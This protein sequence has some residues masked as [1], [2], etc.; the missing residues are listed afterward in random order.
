[1]AQVSSS[2]SS[3]AGAADGTDG[4]RC[5]GNGSCNAGLRCN[6]SVCETAAMGTEGGACFGN[7]SC[8]LGLRCNNNACELVFS[9]GTSSSAGGG[10]SSSTSGG[11]VTGGEG[12]ACYPNSTCDLG[13]DCVNNLC[14]RPVTGNANGPC[15]GNGTC[16]SGLV[17]SNNVCL[18]PP[19]GS[20]GGACYPNLTCNMGLSC[21]GGGCVAGGGSSSSS[22]GG[23]SSSSGGPAIPAPTILG[24]TCDANVHQEACAALADG[25][26]CLGVNPD[27]SGVCLKPNCNTAAPC[28]SGN[29]CTEL[30]DPDYCAASCNGQAGSCGAGNGCVSAV[31]AISGQATNIC[32]SLTIAGCRTDLTPSGCAEGLECAAVG[33]DGFGQCQSNLFLGSPCDP[34]NQPECAAVGGGAQCVGFSGLSEDQGWCV[35]TPCTAGM[36]C[37]AAGTMCVAAGANNFCSSS[38][39]FVEGECGPGDAC[40]G[41]VEGPVCLPLFFASCRVDQVPSGCPATEGCAATGTDGYGNCFPGCDVFAPTCAGADRCFAL[42]STGGICL[43]PTDN[44]A[45]GQ[46]CDGAE[47]C[48]TGLVCASTTGAFTCTTVCDETHPCDQGTCRFQLTSPA[49]GF[50]E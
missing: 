19:Q 14:N 36:A 46:A 35:V 23:G 34:T 33:T 5:Y 31:D 20:L 2:S 27:G 48:G 25:A 17:C 44:R 39:N 16:N 47:Q 38:C 18:P 15:F 42:S 10:A 30:G 8:N 43:P 12:G 4:G 28:A 40:V 1:V 13:L 24:D 7:G 50:C 45:R 22:G 37:G 32:L 41:F 11:A 9:G 3:G 29:V 6:G 26:Q 49:I 21:V